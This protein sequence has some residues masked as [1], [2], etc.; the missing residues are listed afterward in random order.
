MCTLKS[1]IDFVLN[2]DNDHAV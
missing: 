1:D 2:T